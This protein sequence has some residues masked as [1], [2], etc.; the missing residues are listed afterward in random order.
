[1]EHNEKTKI[2]NCIKII[3]EG[4]SDKAVNELYPLLN[5]HLRF[6]A[7][8]YFKNEQ[9]VDYVVSDFWFSINDYCKKVRFLV[10]GRAFLLK[11][12]D[13]LC[14][15]KLRREKKQREIISLDQQFVLLEKNSQPL[16]DD[17]LDLKI[18]IEVAL[19]KL[20]E[21]ERIIVQRI[22]YLEYTTREVAAQLDISKTQVARIHKAALNKLALQLD[23]KN[24]A[25]KE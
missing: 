5:Y 10:N 12:F 4:D 19:A 25:K 17:E 21:I 22:D 23:V 20:D 6:N 1:M 16:S 24:G 3:R 14:L 18:D 9:D 2:N 15:E 7:L 8:R 11:C 13:N